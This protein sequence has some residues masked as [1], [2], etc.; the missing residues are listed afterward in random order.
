MAV[1]QLRFHVLLMLS[2]L[3][4]TSASRKLLVQ[5]VYDR[6]S[7]GLACPIAPIANRHTLK[8][9]GRLS[10]ASVVDVAIMLG[11]DLA[12]YCGSLYQHYQI[13]ILPLALQADVNYSLISDKSTW[14]RLRRFDLG[15]D[16]K[17][18]DKLLFLDLDAYITGIDVDAMFDL[19]SDIDGNRF[20]MG[21]ELVGQYTVGTA[22][23][24]LSYQ[25]NDFQALMETYRQLDAKGIV[26]RTDQ[27]LLAW[28]A[29]ARGEL[30]RLPST[31]SALVPQLYHNYA[32]GN[33][34][35]VHS[36]NR[37]VPLVRVVRFGAAAAMGEHCEG[38]QRNSRMTAGLFHSPALSRLL[39]WICCTS[40][41]V[42][43]AIS[44][45]HLTVSFKSLSV[46][47]LPDAL[48]FVAQPGENPC[49]QQVHVRESRVPQ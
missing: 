14:A 12:H 18:G 38:L 20:R 41:L 42:A 30:H 39:A 27:E 48:G 5:G 49:L 34:L 23:M 36:Q 3:L 11:K 10:G 47:P 40:R 8:I 17:R 4:A 15:N 24:L 9:A 45:H 7:H 21:S 1:S 29:Q 25:P 22:V 35:L 37:S 43:D 6:S 33:E 16:V 31:M 28:H 2:T 44:Q 32:S 46:S 19:V 13:E 26:L